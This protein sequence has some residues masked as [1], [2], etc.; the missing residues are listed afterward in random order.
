MVSVTVSE[1]YD[2]STQVNKM[3]VV[4]IHTPTGSLVDKLWGGLT[5]QYKKFRFAKCDVAMACASVLPADPLQVGI[6]A[7][8]IAP[9]DM[10]NPILYR[11][12]S[13]DSLSN[14]LSYIIGLGAAG[15]DGT[16]S[17][18]V[19]QG[20]VV[21]AS[22]PGFKLGDAELDQQKM[23]YGLL[24]DS[25]GWR[26]AM[27]QAGLAMKGLYPLVYQVVSNFGSNSFVGSATSVL[28]DGKGGATDVNVLDDGHDPSGY[29]VNS[30]AVSAIPSHRIR[31]P[32]MRMPFIDTVTYVN[33]GFKDTNITFPSNAA[34]VASNT[35]KMPPCYVGLIVLPPAVQNKLYYRLKVTWTIEF[36]GLRSLTDTVSWP[37]LE[38]IGDIA[39]GTD[40]AAQSQ[41]MS[42]LEAMMDAESANVTK[43]MEGR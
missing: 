13:N 14:I 7:G 24:A 17:V 30:N 31:G 27:P 40:Y 22:T 3:G 21:S 23:Y 43:V 15:G 41:S 29:V 11:A 33:S 8:E 16:T 20:S 38:T 12:V 25:S 32:S 18:D 42:S 26:K 10:F 4:G 2:L 37:A 39:Y 5:A 6:E 36:V 9:Q 1:T 34:N 19:N 35:G 28:P